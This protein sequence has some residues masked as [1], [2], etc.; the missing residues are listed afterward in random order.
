MEHG[1]C[2]EPGEPEYARQGVQGEYEPFVEEAA[3][4][5]GEDGVEE[6]VGEGE[7]GEDSDE[8]EVG[9][10]GGRFGRVRVVEI[11]GCYMTVKT[12][13]DDSEDE[14]D[15]AE[16]KVQLKHGGLWCTVV[17]VDG[18]LR[19]VELECG[20]ARVCLLAVECG[21]LMKERKEDPVKG[22]AGAFVK[23]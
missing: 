14:L 7:E 8:D 6:E 1:Q 17:L 20:V 4:V 11:P 15:G 12:E 9:G 3:V 2:H 18:G 19:Y 21:E 13:G 10:R 23:R 22:C 5:A 16:R